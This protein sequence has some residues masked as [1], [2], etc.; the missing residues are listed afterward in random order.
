MKAPIF[1]IEQR[2]LFSQLWLGMSCVHSYR[3]QDPK[4]PFVGDPTDR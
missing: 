2:S 1:V 3:G 4:K